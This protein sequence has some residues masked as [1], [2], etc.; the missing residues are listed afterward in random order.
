MLLRRGPNGMA[1]ERRSSEQHHG[2]NF[3]F[4][5]TRLPPTLSRYLLQEDHCTDCDT[6]AWEVQEGD[7]LLVFSDGVR[8]NL[9]DAE[10]LSIVDRTVPPVLADLAGLPEHATPPERVA[11]A[12]ASAARLRSVDPAARVPFNIYSRRHG[13]ERTGGKEDDITVVAAWVLP[14]CGSTIPA[15]DAARALQLAPAGLPRV[16][17]TWPDE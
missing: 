10:I 13:L 12:L 9:H 3:P 1:I 4:Q 15:F 5:L 7:L 11:R 6:Y 14:E 17:G 16:A 8:D 2:W